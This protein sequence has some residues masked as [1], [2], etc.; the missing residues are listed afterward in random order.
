MRD[1]GFT[2][3]ELIMVLVILGIISTFAASRFADRQS[4]SGRAIVNQLLA[5]ARLAQQTAFAQSSAS[6]VQ[7]QVNRSGDQWNFQ[8]RGGDGLNILLDAGNEQIRFGTNLSTACSALS[9]ASLTLSFNGQGS[10]VSGQNTR[11]C[12]VDDNRSREIC[13]S[14]AGYAYEGNC[15]L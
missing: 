11:I 5:T 10:L 9:N 1:H 12:V 4:Y 14:S 2:L 6:N 13:I 3:V 15:V 7:L 8:V